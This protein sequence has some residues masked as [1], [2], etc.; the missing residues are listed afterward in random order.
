MNLDRPF[1][2]GKKIY[3]RPLDVEDIDQYLRWVND[4]RVIGHLGTLHFPTTR[5]ALREYLEKN[6]TDKNTAF[7]AIVEKRTN[8]HI[9]NIKLGPIDW[10]NRRAE[11][12]RLIGDVAAQ[13]K[14]YGTESVRLI[15]KYAFDNL[16]LHKVTSSASEDNMASLK[17]NQKAG[18]IVEATL[19]EQ[20]YENGV[21]KD[22]ILLGITKKE[23]IRAHRARRRKTK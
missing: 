12:G 13:G 10:I 18:L 9:G 15:L 20:K 3:L 16:N 5:E 19:K 4:E 17:S 21:Y 2:T 11:Y 23:Y 8:K 6:T 14:G 1:L 22:I 7:F